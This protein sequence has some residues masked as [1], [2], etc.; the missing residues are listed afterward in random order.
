M[1][2]TSSCSS[3]KLR[4]SFALTIALVGHD[5]EPDCADLAANYMTLPSAGVEQI[6][7]LVDSK[8]VLTV[9]ARSAKSPAIGQ[10]FGLPFGVEHCAR[11]KTDSIFVRRDPT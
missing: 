2:G 11:R 10:S 4:E 6:P 5:L 8:Q 7:R 9:T 3:G 1:A